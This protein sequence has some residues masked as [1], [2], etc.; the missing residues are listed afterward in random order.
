MAEIKIPVRVEAEQAIAN[1][2]KTKQATEEL[3][4]TGNTVNRLG[5]TTSRAM[6]GFKKTVADNFNAA[7][8]AVEKFGSRVAFEM[9]NIKANIGDNMNNM[10]RAIGALAQGNI[11]AAG[12]ALSGFGGAMAK[13]GP[14]AL[15]T[16]F[17]IKQLVG[18]FQ[19]IAEA[20]KQARLETVETY[21]KAA[22]LAAENASR[23]FAKAKNEIAAFAK[24]KDSAAKRDSE[25]AK[26]NESTDRNNLETDRIRA[27]SGASNQAERDKINSDFDARAGAI[28]EAERQ[29]V[30]QE[31]RDRIVREREKAEAE[32]KALQDAIKANTK[33][34]S[35]ASR[36]AQDAAETAD[37]YMP[38]WIRRNVFTW[39]AN[40]RMALAQQF[41][42]KQTAAVDEQ[43]RIMGDS[44]DKL[45][46]IKDLNAALE[47]LAERE[48][49][50]IPAM[51]ESATSADEL[52]K[53][54]REAAEAAKINSGKEQIEAQKAAVAEAERLKSLTDDVLENELAA[55][56]ASKD[57]AK[58]AAASGEQLR[59]QDLDKRLASVKSEAAERERIKKLTDAQ[60]ASE[61]KIAEQQRDIEKHTRLTTEQKERAA[62]I[63]RIGA[64]KAEVAEAQRLKEIT[65]AQLDAEIAKTEA[66]GKFAEWQKL[67][68]ELN[69]RKDA[70]KQIGAAKA[71]AAERERINKLTAAQLAKEIEIA[72]V[73]R[74]VAA[75]ARLEAE[76]KNRIAGLEKMREIAIAQNRDNPLNKAAEQ[77]LRKIQNLDLARQGNQINLEAFGRNAAA[78][79]ATAE[80]IGAVLA[81]KLGAQRDGDP[82]AQKTVEILQKIFREDER[83]TDRLA[84][85]LTKIVDAIDKQKPKWGG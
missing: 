50:V 55:A 80:Q 35:M 34:G 1:L 81:L 11:P 57:Y 2:Q 9:K 22:G 45:Q 85:G 44:R 61:I 53:A 4:N 29:R 24:A 3:K 49:T 27:L 38:S 74:D 39:G 42:D 54:T 28:D 23:Q 82:A 84:D 59:R 64:A 67:T 40:D 48:R 37:E 30:I 21:M 71:E 62:E 31:E 7:K 5:E 20:R 72:K 58:W 60:L 41:I 13:L 26:L 79:G 68:A 16:S 14:V 18:M 78:H 10:G 65:D 75:A 12:K 63:D 77:A 52:A 36:A 43:G 47:E 33:A 15:V 70:D 76:Q 32:I 51:E 8:S 66:A 69:R 17:A 83:S 73:Q 56:E 19:R 25:I 6:A 46:Q